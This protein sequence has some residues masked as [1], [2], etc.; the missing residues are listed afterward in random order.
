[1]I[2]VTGH[3][4]SG[5]TL[6]GQ[7]LNS[8]PQMAVTHE[9]GMVMAADQLL[10][11][12]IRAIW[13]RVQVVDTRWSFLPTSGKP[14]TI[15]WANRWLAL[16][17][18]LN[19]V[20]VTRGVVDFDVIDRAWRMTFPQAQLVGDKLPEYASQLHKYMSQDALSTIYIYRDC[21]DVTS[22]FLVKTRTDWRGQAWT[23]KWQTAG[24]VAQRWVQRIEVMEKWSQQM[25]VVRYEDLVQTPEHVLPKLG[26]W[27]NV[28]PE[29]FDKGRL[30]PTSVGN[31][32]KT[33]TDQD[34][35]EI[36][37]VA[38]PTMARLDYE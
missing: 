3:Q 15:K 24:A 1:M 25:L 38:G 18:L 6:L 28:D 13:K 5:T 30:R 2:L 10:W 29:G 33:L 31:Y 26:A 16:R 4:R 36:M 35:A 34:V 17:Y 12:Y 27:L 37:A 32:K 7:L 14:Q 22:S 8:H 20:R 9:F 21:R 19:V 23:E 11:P